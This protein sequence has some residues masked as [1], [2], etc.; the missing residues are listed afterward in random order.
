MPLQRGNYVSHFT[1]PGSSSC[2]C[3]RVCGS[4][5]VASNIELMGKPIFVV[6]LMIS[7]MVVTA[8]DSASIDF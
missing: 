5:P 7:D 4:N 1:L 2:L 6:F 8:G 3:A